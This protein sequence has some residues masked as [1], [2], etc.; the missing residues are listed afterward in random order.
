MPVWPAELPG[1]AIGT[2]NESPPNNVIAS[3]PDKGPAIVR[4]RTTANVRPLS[5]SMMLT[6]EELQTLD[7][8]FTDETDY[9]SVPFDYDH[10]RTGDAC[11]ARFKP[12]SVP[13]YLDREGVI[14]GVA[15]ELEILP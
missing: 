9:G 3:Q 1:P 11:T 2:L 10:P 12:G 7:D 4:R 13:Q 5:F 6:S 8:F 14:Y 15:V